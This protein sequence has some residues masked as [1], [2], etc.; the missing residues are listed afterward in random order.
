MAAGGAVVKNRQLSSETFQFFN[1]I[2]AIR[3]ASKSNK[4]NDRH[5]L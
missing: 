3:N 1:P 2:R 5:L 4:S